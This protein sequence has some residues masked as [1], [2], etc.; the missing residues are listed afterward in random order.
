MAKTVFFMKW[1][2]RARYKTK[3]GRLEIKRTGTIESE[4]Q[5]KSEFTL[6][7]KQ[8][9]AV[10]LN[11]ATVKENI[12]VADG[13]TVNLW[14]Q[15]V[16]LDEN[17]RWKARMKEQEITRLKTKISNAEVELARLKYKLSEMEA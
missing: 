13:R 17:D 4:E 10:Q 1:M 2:N 14:S 3:E 9:Y 5:A 16:V 6:Y 8:G 15:T 12:K 11:S 7:T